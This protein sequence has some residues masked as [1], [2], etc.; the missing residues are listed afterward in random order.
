[1]LRGGLV[2]LGGGRIGGR[3][4]TGDGRSEAG[5]VDAV[6][7]VVVCPVVG[8]FDSVAQV[9]GEEVE[10]GVRLV[11]E[12]VEGVVEHAD[13]L[14]AFIVDDLAL[15]LVVQRRHREAAA[16]VGVVLEVDVA[17]V[18]V[19]GVEGIGRYVRAWHVF[20]GRREPPSWTCERMRW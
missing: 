15:L 4:R 8:G 19:V 18:G 6:V 9:F 2:S 17:Q 7:D 12:V 3:R 1:M 13:D 14:A 20:V 11:E 5:F 16:V 10:L